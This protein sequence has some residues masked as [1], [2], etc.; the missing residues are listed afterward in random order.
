MR[1]VEVSFSTAVDPHLHP[2]F[3]VGLHIVD[4]FEGGGGCGSV[5]TFHVG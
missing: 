2:A 4:I 1:S 3:I 5:N